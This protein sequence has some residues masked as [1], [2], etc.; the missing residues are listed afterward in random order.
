MIFSAK[1]LHKCPG[2]ALRHWNIQQH[3]MVNTT[4]HDDTIGCKDLAQDIWEL[5]CFEFVVLRASLG[6]LGEG[7]RKTERSV[8][9]ERGEEKL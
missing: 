2:L 6:H 3:K 7:I 8:C 5:L 1:G 4:D 9:E